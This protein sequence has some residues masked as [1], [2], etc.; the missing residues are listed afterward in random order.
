MEK[1]FIAIFSLLPALV[2][3]YIVYITMPF[4]SISLADGMRFIIA[5]IFSVIILKYF[6]ILGISSTVPYKVLS[7]DMTDVTM[8]YKHY[9]YFISVGLM[10]ELSKLLAFFIFAWLM[11]HINKETMHPIAIMFYCGMVGLG[12]AVA[13]NVHYANNAMQ[14]FN[15]L[16]W[17]SIAPI[18]THMTCGFFMGYWI[19]LSK[20]SP[21]MY[22]RSLFDIIIHKREKLSRFIYTLIGLFCATILHGVYDLHLELNG[23]G[24]ISGVYM[25]MILSS[26]GVLYCFNHIYKLNKIKENQ[27]INGEES[28]KEENSNKSR[29]ISESYKKGFSESQK[30][31]EENKRNC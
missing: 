28:S 13:E 27:L 7:G 21:R 18:L 25:L 1:L 5:G 19:S 23:I 31:C 17:R 26:L 20:M 16:W 22:N 24:G 3:A 9:Q 10:E 11:N 4:K 12:F 30:S 8:G 29:D 6:S 15:V 2:Y 14:P